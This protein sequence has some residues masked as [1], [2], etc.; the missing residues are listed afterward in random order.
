MF[1]K[2]K[3]HYLVELSIWPRGQKPDT[4]PWRPWVINLSFIILPN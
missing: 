2:I 4:L 1:H 3:F